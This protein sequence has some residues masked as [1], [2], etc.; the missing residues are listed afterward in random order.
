MSRPCC[1]AAHARLR[2]RPT[3][4]AS[5][6]QLE[7]LRNGKAYALSMKAPSLTMADTE[8]PARTTAK[9]ARHSPK[10]LLSLWSR[11]DLADSVVSFL[12]AKAIAG[13]A[14]VSKPL[15]EA[16]P[17]VVFAAARRRN[18]ADVVTR[19]CFEALKTGELS[20]FRET[21]TDGLARWTMMESVRSCY[22]FGTVGTPPQLELERDASLGSR[23]GFRGF[24]CPFSGS[25]GRIKRFRMQVALDSVEASLVNRAAGYAILARH[26]PGDLHIRGDL[27]GTHFKCIVDDDGERTG[28]LKLQWLM[29]NMQGINTSTLLAGNV[30]FGEMYTIAASFSYD[31]DAACTARVSVNEQPAIS[32]TGQLR[33]LSAL[34]LYNLDN[35]TA[36]YGDIDVWYE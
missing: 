32:F 27:A 33:P 25:N 17:R 15:L 5:S 30:R 16:Q 35:G 24:Y 3:C 10:L 26:D 6:A 9:A 2:P 23:T 11:T 21:W 4:S 7:S 8:S 12:P 1:K 28:E 13:L 18:V 36:R 14:L 22:R 31:S 19:A 20:H 29:K 34:H